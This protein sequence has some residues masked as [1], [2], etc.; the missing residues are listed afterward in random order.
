MFTTRADLGSSVRC[1][2]TGP[3]LNGSDGPPRMLPMGFEPTSE[4]LSDKGEGFSE[5]DGAILCV[6][7]I[8]PS[9][10][11]NGGKLVS[12]SVFSS[13]VDTLL[14][15]SVPSPISEFTDG[16]I[17]KLERSSG[18]LGMVSVADFPGLG[19]LS[20]VGSEAACEDAPLIR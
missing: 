4:Q 5:D 1:A 14:Q 10:E 19:D 11:V 12:D 6:D 3:S 15:S 17:V 8:L 9:L 20:G 16:L 7:G 13:L 2:G 18:P